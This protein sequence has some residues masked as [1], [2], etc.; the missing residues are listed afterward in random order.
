M[1][2]LTWKNLLFCHLIIYIDFHSLKCNVYFYCFLTKSNSTTSLDNSTLDNSKSLISQILLNHLKLPVRV[3]VN[4][5]SIV[6]FLSTQIMF[7]YLKNQGCTLRLNLVSMYYCIFY[8]YKVIIFH[9]Y[10]FR[11]SKTLTHHKRSVVT[12]Y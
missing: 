4:Y 3:I 11:E 7:L 2:D 9:L 1:Y 6:N 5:F 8:N 10:C 12:K